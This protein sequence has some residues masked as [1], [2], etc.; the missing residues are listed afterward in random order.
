[1]RL[2]SSSV[3]RGLRPAPGRS[4]YRQTV[5]VEPVQTFSAPSADGLP[6]PPHDCDG[7]TLPAR[8]DHPGPASP[9]PQSTPSTSQL[10]HLAIATSSFGVTHA[11]PSPR[12]R[13]QRSI[14]EHSTR[15]STGV[16]CIPGSKK[17]AH[18]TKQLAIALFPLFSWLNVHS[19]R[20]RGR[21]SL[22]GRMAGSYFILTAQ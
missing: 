4:A 5:N 2:R 19:C 9:G 17:R 12:Q 22:P 20:T 6:P 21:L 16:P 7:L 18:T 15:R 11:P 10:T 13:G 14:A 3:S 1:M 8:S